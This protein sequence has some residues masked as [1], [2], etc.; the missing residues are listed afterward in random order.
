MT[1]DQ[2]LDYVQRHPD[3]AIC[4]EAGLIAE[5]ADRE[6]GAAFDGGTLLR[7][8]SEAVLRA[9]RTAVFGP[10]PTCAHPVVMLPDGR[11]FSWPLP[12]R[13]LHIC[14]VEATYEPMK[15]SP[16]LLSL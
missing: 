7:A 4:I 14:V 8:T 2:V 11:P 1:D 9:F 5:Q 13:A 6:S 15:K 3:L 16:Q 10:C 12:E